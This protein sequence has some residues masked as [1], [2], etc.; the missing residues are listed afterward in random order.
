MLTNEQRDEAAREWGQKAFVE[1][2][3]TATINL[4]DIREAVM[5]ADAAADAQVKL[6]TPREFTSKAEEHWTP[7]LTQLVDAKRTEVVE[8][9][10]LAAAE[11][12]AVAATPP[13]VPAD[14]KP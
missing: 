11:A 4:D 9:A 1:P 12:E 10:K 5:A 3:R 7:L 8:K 14:T 13:D 2:N 6:S